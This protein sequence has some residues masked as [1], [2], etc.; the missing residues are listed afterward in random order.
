MRLLAR[1]SLTAAVV[2]VGY[3]AVTA[4]QVYLAAQRDEPRDADAIVVLGAAQ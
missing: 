2:L 3:V 4:V 1:L